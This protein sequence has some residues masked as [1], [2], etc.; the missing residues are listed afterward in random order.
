METLLEKNIP[1][2]ITLSEENFKKLF[3][4]SIKLGEDRSGCLAPDDLAGAIPEIMSKVIEIET[5]EKL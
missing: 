5:A 2:G 4:R 1:D 3:A